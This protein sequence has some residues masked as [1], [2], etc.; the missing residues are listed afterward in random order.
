MYKRSLKLSEYEVVAR[1]GP[2]SCIAKADMYSSGELMPTPGPEG[3]QFVGARAEGVLLDGLLGPAPDLEQGRLPRPCLAILDRV[4]AGP[5]RGCRQQ[6][7]GGPV[8]DVVAALPSAVALEQPLAQGQVVPA[9]EGL[10]DRVQ[11]GH[12]ILSRAE[13]RPDAHRLGPGHLEQAQPSH[14]RQS[15]PA[16]FG[17]LLAVHVCGLDHLLLDLCSLLS[18][19]DQ[20]ARDQAARKEPAGGVLLGVLDGQ[21]PDYRQLAEVHIVE[22]QHSPAV[23]AADLREDDQGPVLVH[24]QFLPPGNDAVEDGPLFGG[25]L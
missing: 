4:L 16:V 7:S 25:V 5:R 24:G 18:C 1:P 3:G 14:A 23:G 22:G 11:L 15:V 13:A 17:V 6:S 10:L 2:R 20:A 8:Q 21:Q 12:L 9:G 19:Q